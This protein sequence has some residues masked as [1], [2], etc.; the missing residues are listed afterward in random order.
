MLLEEKERGDKT[1]FILEHLL[2]ARNFKYVISFDIQNTPSSIHSILGVKK[3]SSLSE[4]IRTTIGPFEVWLMLQEMFLQCG[5]KEERREA[6]RE[7]ERKEEREIKSY[8]KSHKG[9]QGSLFPPSLSDPKPLFFPRHQAVSL[10]RS[11]WW[12]PKSI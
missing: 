2:C 7:G 10:V 5:R 9:K 12:T 1:N 8:D 4:Y 3:L 11:P 6:G